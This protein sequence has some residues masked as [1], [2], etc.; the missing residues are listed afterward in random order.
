M[1]SNP[2]ETAGIAKITFGKMIQPLPV[3]PTVYAHLCRK[4]HPRR[5]HTGNLPAATVDR[6]DKLGVQ[7]IP[8]GSGKNRHVNPPS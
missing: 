3:T 4:R 1:R 5:C 2:P 6:L 7:N 8:A